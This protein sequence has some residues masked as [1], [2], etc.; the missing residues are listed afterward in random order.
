MIETL[1]QIGFGILRYSV[2][3]LKRGV[4]KEKVINDDIIYRF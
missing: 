4:I 1:W 3:I 2:D